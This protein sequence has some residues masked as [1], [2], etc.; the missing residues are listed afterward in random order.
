MVAPLIARVAAQA[1]K[2][3]AKKQV[4]KGAAKANA[5]KNVAKKAARIKN[6][7]SEVAARSKFRKRVK[8]RISEL[9]NEL[10]AGVGGVARKRVQYEKDYLEKRLAGSYA[11]KLGKYADTIESLQHLSENVMVGDPATRNERLTR[12]IL[13]SPVGSRIYG[14]LEKIWNV[15]GVD[16][17]SGAAIDKAIMDKFGVS[18]MS[19][20]VDKLQDEVS[21]LFDPAKNE[22]IK[23][24]EVKEQIAYYVRNNLGI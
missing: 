12:N 22:Q 4:A 17:K 11:D 3:A 18:S 9:E 23:Y 1:A 20:V 6:N 15:E 21:T 13:S 10:D 5:A 2:G 19:E 8:R 7:P 14:G 24:D 16:T